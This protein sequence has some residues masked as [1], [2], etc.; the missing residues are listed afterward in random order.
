MSSNA[1]SPSITACCWYESSGIDNDK[2]K[3]YSSQTHAT[4][5]PT[6]Q[7]LDH[8]NRGNCDWQ[9]AMWRL[10]KE[11][12][13]KRETWIEVKIANIYPICLHRH[14]LKWRFCIRVNQRVSSANGA[15][16][17]HHYFHFCHFYRCFCS[18]SSFAMH[19]RSIHQPLSLWAPHATRSVLRVKHVK[20]R[21]SVRPTT[22]LIII[23]K[24]QVAS[25]WTGRRLS[26]SLRCYNGNNVKI[27]TTHQMETKQNE[28]ERE[29]EIEGERK[30]LRPQLVRY[31][32]LPSLPPPTTTT[33]TTF[34]KF[35]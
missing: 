21:S 17:D 25:E 15:P 27:N 5:C 1:A 32:L 12:T 4:S 23:I 30:S 6:H 19:N 7:W 8:D 28:R 26:V 20:I 24:L 29:R 22:K 31:R 16:T 13:D 11:T 3:T 2:L 10:G 9:T 35:R 18:C 34:T 14:R 33:T